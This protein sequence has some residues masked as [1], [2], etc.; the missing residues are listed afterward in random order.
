MNYVVNTVADRTGVR[1]DA[2]KNRQG[3]V[4]SIFTNFMRTSSM[5]NSLRAS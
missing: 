3:G 5:G 1:L 2:D 4:E